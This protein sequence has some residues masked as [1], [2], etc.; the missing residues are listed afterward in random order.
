MMIPWK[1]KTLP[2]IKVQHNADWQPGTEAEGKHIAHFIDKPVLT[3]FGKEI[4]KSWCVFAVVVCACYLVRVCGR[5]RRCRRFC[6][7]I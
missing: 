3:I 5:L 7:A 6:V 1:F 2:L 4:P